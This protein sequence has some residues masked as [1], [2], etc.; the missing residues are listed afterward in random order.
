MVARV[1]VQAVIPL[2]HIATHHSLIETAPHIPEP[3]AALLRGPSW[4]HM[5]VHWHWASVAVKP[6]L[7]MSCLHTCA[8]VKSLT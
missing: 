8:N 2:A 7:S 1:E 5:Q 4:A 3:Q 6:A